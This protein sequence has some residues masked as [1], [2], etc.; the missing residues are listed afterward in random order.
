LILCYYQVMKHEFSTKIYY[1]DTDSYGVVWHGSY[2]RWLERGRVDFSQMVGI[3]IDE[4]HKDGIVLPVIDLNIRYKRSAKI[5]EE[6][7]IETT[8][9]EVKSPFVK[10]SQVIKNKETGKV[11][12]VASVSCVALDENGNMLRKIPDFLAQAYSSKEPCLL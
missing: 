5:N 3:D 7:T 12:V 4:L 10:F 1:A 9:E 11:N 2:L 8:V 6:I